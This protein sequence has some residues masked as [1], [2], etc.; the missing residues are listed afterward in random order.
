MLEDERFIQAYAQGKLPI[1]GI[2]E[3]DMEDEVI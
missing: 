1:R 3:I 2:G